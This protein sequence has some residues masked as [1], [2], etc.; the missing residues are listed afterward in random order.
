V[1]APG[2]TFLIDTAPELRLQLLR[3]KIP[4]VHA[5]IYTHAHADH[6]FGLD[7]LRL[8]GHVLGKPVPLYCE[9]NVEAQILASYAYAFA[10]PGEPL[11]PGA[12]PL[13][14]LE[15]IGTEPFELL[16]QTVQPI[17]LIH[18]RLPVLGFRFGNVAFC[19]DV[20]LIPD[21]SWP[22]LEGLDVLIL[23]CLRE[24]PH[25]THFGLP[26]SLAVVERVRPKQTYFTHV[27]HHLD[28]DATNAKLPPGVTLA[29]D[30]LRIE[31]AG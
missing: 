29:Y 17:R 1:H 22:L 23:D 14:T 25:A 27:S 11:H 12:L 2:G 8:F 10:P 19:T 20:S 18:G 24:Y 30:G 28:Y 31:I 9:E 6:L 7:D 15:R 3:E 21:E 4:L 5:V 16:G 13:L 26:Q